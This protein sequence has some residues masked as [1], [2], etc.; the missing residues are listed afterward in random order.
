MDT[1]A[2]EHAARR[3]AL[4]A[5]LRARGAGSAAPLG[6]GK[7]SSNLFRDRQ[8]SAKQRLDLSDFCHVLAIDTAQGWV[9][10][11]GLATYEALV[12]QTLKQ[13][14]MPAVVPQLKTITVGG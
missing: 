10:V 2:S 1:E 13:G 5:Q 12:A 7:H 14:V 6:L 4:A 3:A 8:Q 9:D 11:E